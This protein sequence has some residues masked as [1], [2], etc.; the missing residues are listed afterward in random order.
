MATQVAVAMLAQ[1]YGSVG[2]LNVKPHV[3]SQSEGGDSR[4]AQLGEEKWLCLLLVDLPRPMQE[5]IL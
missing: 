5:E 3:F 1:V 2:L 4:W